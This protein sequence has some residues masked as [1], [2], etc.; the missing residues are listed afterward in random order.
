[1]KLALIQLLSF[2][3]FISSLFSK[4]IT[5]N[6]TAEIYGILESVSAGD[7][8]LIKSG[9]YHLDSTAVWK[10]GG[11]K[12]CPAVILGE[13]HDTLE[14]IKGLPE[15]ALREHMGSVFVMGG[16]RPK[17]GADLSKGFD[18]T[19][20]WIRDV[21]TV[22]SAFSKL[23]EAGKKVFVFSSDQFGGSMVA[24]TDKNLG[25]GEVMFSELDR[26]GID[27]EVLAAVR[28]HWERW[29]RV[30]GHFRS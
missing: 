29:S 8:I 28:D 16:G 23:G 3:S 9:E 19:R 6:N 15:A 12:T 25:N 24:K 11:E 27:S 21:D 13:G 22:F 7:T 26:L 18:R 1:M 5:I 4:P 20:N 30:F 10:K 17:D 14:T 2:L